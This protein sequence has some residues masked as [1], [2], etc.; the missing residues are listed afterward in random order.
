[1]KEA[2]LDKAVLAPGE[3][4]VALVC[5]WLVNVGGAERVLLEFHKM[6]PEA[7]IY[8]S[9][10]D[11]RKIDWF[12]DAEV[13]TGWM[14]HLPVFLRR[15]L[16]PLRQRY[17]ARLDLSA[18]DLVISVT[19]AEAKF[20]KIP[21]SSRVLD[22][23]F[24]KNRSCSRPSR[25][26]MSRFSG[27]PDASTRDDHNR[28]IHICFC[29][30]PTQ[31]YW[32]LYDD[33]LERPGFGI[34]NPLVRI[35]LKMFIKPLRKAD[36]EAA[37]GPDYYITISKYAAEQ[38]KKYYKREARVINPPVDVQKFRPEKFPK[39]AQVQG[40]RSGYFITTSRQVTW[41]RIDL[42]IEAAV[43]ADV[44]LLVIG[45]GPEH[46]NLLKLARKLQPGAVEGMADGKQTIG[47]VTFIPVLSQEELKPY[48]EN[49]RGYLF[50]SK[51]PFGIAPVEA[52]AAGCP[53]IAFNAGGARDYIRPGENGVLFPKQSAGSLAKAIREFQKLY[54][55]RR[56]VSASAESYDTPVFIRK[57]QEL[58]HEI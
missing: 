46:K 7:P 1:M 16:A 54:F 36:F 23:S 24:P 6:F 4:K 52:I 55:N 2:V 38:I 20:V 28:P 25:G 37:Q 22:A 30:V 29:H 35:A 14:Q 40:E 13:R 32:E 58:L 26:G 48:L 41:K 5:D 21:G 18:Y 57:I 47:R 12:R 3:L 10:Y 49:A 11:P 43:K 53:V 9:Q 51:E 50:P 56:E 44:N 19:G 45:D 27:D 31:Y 17:F 39:S 15:F 33:Y 42:C 34:L 8:T